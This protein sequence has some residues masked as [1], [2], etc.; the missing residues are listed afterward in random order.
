MVVR[1]F[2]PA[3]KSFL[4]DGF[5]LTEAK[6][7]ITYLDE[8]TVLF[9][10][11]FGAGSMTTSGYP[12]LVKLWKRG[13]PMA[14]ARTV[15]EGQD[16]DVASAGVVFRNPAGTLALVQRAVSFFT[17]EYYAL[18]PD[19]TTHLMPLPLG[20]DLKGAQGGDLIFT[21]REDWTPPGGAPIAKGSLIAYRA[22]AAADQA[23][24]PAVS[25]LFTPDAHG[26]I[27]EV[28][29]GRDAV[30]ASIYHD[31]T[32]SVHVFRPRAA[33]RAGATPA[34]RCRPAARPISCRPTPGARKL[35]PLRELHDADHACTPTLAMASRRRSNRCRRA[36]TPPISRPSSSSPPPRRHAHSVLRDACQGL[37]RARA[38]GAVRLW[39]FR[40][41]DDPEL[42]GQFRHA[43]ADA[44][45]RLCGRQHPRGR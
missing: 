28:A 4:K 41:L 43:V 22:A 15:Y 7:S 11:D 17:T 38:G 36:S 12:R 1:E 42:L 39:R 25:V 35:L 16:S 27:D 26:S 32:G 21:L 18:A 20:A 8:D 31:V 29:T 34:C 13:T 45:R 33:G 44:R 24:P 14:E 19:G 5:T 37:S 6:S 2:D 9:G 40:D 23:A 30:Y 3:G 10:T